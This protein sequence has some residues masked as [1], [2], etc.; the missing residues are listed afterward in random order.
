[1][2]FIKIITELEYLCQF[3]PKSVSTKYSSKLVDSCETFEP[4]RMQLAEISIYRQLFKNC[5]KIQLS[6]LIAENKL[7]KYIV[8]FNWIN[9]FSTAYK[10]KLYYKGIRFSHC[11]L[12]HFVTKNLVYPIF[13]ESQKIPFNPIN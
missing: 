10:K 9:D 5:N 12:Q 13:K 8:Q 7:L 4:G 2:Y 6:A 1:M 3:A 11:S